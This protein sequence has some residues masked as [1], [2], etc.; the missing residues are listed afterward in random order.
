MRDGEVVDYNED[1]SVLSKT[2][3]LDNVRQGNFY[4]KNTVYFETGKFTNDLEDS[5]W[6]SF[7]TKTQTK[8]F[9]GRYI[10]GEPEGTHRYFY[11]NGKPAIL[12]IYKNGLKDGTWLFYNKEG[13]LYLTIQ[14]KN[15]EEISW[16]GKKINTEGMLRERNLNNNYN[17]KL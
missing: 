6:V 4:F 7:Y 13:E 9:E 5:I 15:D 3:F 1:G 2:V 10:N 8:R 11:D 12:A 16:Q 17:S 14:Y